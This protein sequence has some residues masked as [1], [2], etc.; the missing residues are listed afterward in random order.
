MTSKRTSILIHR[1]TVDRL[2]EIGRFGESYDDLINRMIDE[3]KEFQ[4][5]KKVIE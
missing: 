3:R 1:T 5:A 4:E 2:R